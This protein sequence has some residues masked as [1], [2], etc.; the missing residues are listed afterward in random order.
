MTFDYSKELCEIC[1]IKPR[2]RKYPDFE[3]PENFVK[4][5]EL[6]FMDIADEAYITLASF[7][8]ITAPC[9]RTSF[10]ENLICVLEMCWGQ[11][12]RNI[13]KAMQE[14]EWVYE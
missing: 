6:E 7:T 3:K 10:L 14:T 9:N 5:Y 8:N 4:L 12:R 13:I 2:R 11:N 1:N